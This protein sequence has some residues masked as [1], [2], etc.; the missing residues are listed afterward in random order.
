MYTLRA[1]ASVAP[2]IPIYWTMNSFP[3]TASDVPSH[4][5]VLIAGEFIS[6][7]P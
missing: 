7:E 3:E 6:T 5:V 2:A 4:V 1:K